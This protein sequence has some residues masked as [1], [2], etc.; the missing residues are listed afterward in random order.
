MRV[1]ECGQLSVSKTGLCDKAQEVQAEVH[2]LRSNAVDPR[3]VRGKVA[4]T[5][6]ARI[7]QT[8]TRARNG[9]SGDDNGNLPAY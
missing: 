4:L 7:V 3:F 1:V 2:G 9:L 5:S 8:A 6:L